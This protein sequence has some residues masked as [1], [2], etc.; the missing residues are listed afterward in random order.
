VTESAVRTAQDGFL[1][2]DIIEDAVGQIIGH[3]DVFKR[4]RPPTGFVYLALV[5]RSKP[6]V[7]PKLVGTFQIDDA[8]QIGSRARVLQRGT[9]HQVIVAGMRL[10]DLSIFSELGAD[11]EHRLKRLGHN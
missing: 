7:P 5:E 10:P 11:I 3:A 4:D 9:M 2:G 1:P 8:P 6:R